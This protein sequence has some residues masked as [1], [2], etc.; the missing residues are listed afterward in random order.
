[1]KKLSILLTIL[2]ALLVFGFAFQNQAVYQ[3]EEITWETDFDEALKTAKKKNKK[4][5]VLFT[6]SDWCGWCKKLDAEVFKK[7][8]FSKYANESFICVKL[9][10]PRKSNQTQAEKARNSALAQE[11]RVQGFPTVFVLNKD[12]K[13]LHQTGYQRGGPEKY[14]TSLEQALAKSK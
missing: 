9:D 8:D 2:V 13:V 5:F 14:K 3:T 6:G 12:K 7:D 1:M 11:F 10:F 4:L